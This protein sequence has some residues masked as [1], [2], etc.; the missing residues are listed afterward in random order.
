LAVEA[1]QRVGVSEEALRAKQASRGRFD[2]ADTYWRIANELVLDMMRVGHLQQAGAIYR[3]MARFLLAEGKPPAD[4][5]KT[6]VRCE[7]LAL[8]SEAQGSTDLAV[9]GCSCPGCSASPR[10]VPVSVLDELGQSSRELPAAIPLPHD[11]CESGLCPCQLKLV[12][13]QQAGG[14]HRGLSRL[15]ERHKP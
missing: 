9:Y 10:S 12:R 13:G 14:S 7:A 4:L 15:F 1:A 6:A 5:L 8:R 3:E 2:L 11:H